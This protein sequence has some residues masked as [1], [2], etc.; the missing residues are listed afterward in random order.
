MS[1]TTIIATIGPASNTSEI[2]LALHRAGMTVARL[3]GSHGSLDWHRATIDLIRRTLPDLPILLDIPGRKIRTVQLRTEPSF[4]AGD[5]LVLTTDLSHD[6]SSKV[7][8]N[9]DRFHLRL[10]AGVRIYADDGTLSFVVED[11]RGQDVHVV[12]ETAGTLKSRKG[13]NVP[14]IDLGQ[15]LVTPRDREMIAFAKHA[16]VDFIGISFVESA[17][18]VEAIRALIGAPSPRIVAKVENR[19]GL[20]HLD[21]IAGATDVIM[22]DRGDLSV[23]TS[24]DHVSLYQKRIIAAARQHGKPVIVATELLHSMIES[25]L[26]T[27]AEIGDVTNAVI[28]GAS[29]V[30]LSG[31]TAVGKFPL[32]AVARLRSIVT[33]AEAHRHTAVSAAGGPA[34][35]PNDLRAATLA[36]TRT[37]PVSKVVVLSR[38]GYAARLVSMAQ[39]RQPIIAVGGDAALARTWNLLPGTTAVCLPDLDL[40]ADGAGTAALRALW[41]RGWLQGDDVA[42]VVLAASDDAQASLSSLQTVRVGQLA[43]QLAWSAANGVEA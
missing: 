15:Q 8:V 21:E 40:T 30:M 29:A 5:R 33:L 27:K 38:T 31:E 6:G 32:E 12:A 16:G 39:V 1:K 35:A 10:R 25:P 19:G 37:L 23:E 22:I 20:D 28:D 18:H 41:E 34:D 24:I 43:A 2:L 11:V 17:E 9:Y 26:P 42:L 36:L 14:E 3:N 7:P 13:V 4:Q